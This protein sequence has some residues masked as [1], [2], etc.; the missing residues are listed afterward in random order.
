MSPVRKYVGIFGSLGSLW[1][2]HESQTTNERTL[3]II[4]YKK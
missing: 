3:K 4:T 2:K 1:E